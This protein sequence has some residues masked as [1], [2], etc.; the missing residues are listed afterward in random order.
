MGFS[1]LDT[2]NLTMIFASGGI[3]ADQFEFAGYITNS[4]F[5]AAIVTIAILLFTRMATRR[6]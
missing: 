5:V 2:L 1:S 6:M 3:A 4:I